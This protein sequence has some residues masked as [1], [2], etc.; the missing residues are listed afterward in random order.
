MTLSFFEIKLFASAMIIFL[1][2]LSIYRLKMIPFDLKKTALDQ[3]R[4]WSATFLVFLIICLLLPEQWPAYAVYPVSLACAYI[5]AGFAILHA[6]KQETFWQKRRN[7]VIGVASL[8]V[9][10]LV[11]PQL[12]TIPV[13]FPVLF[14]MVT[15]HVCHTYSNVFFVESM[16][17]IDA[18]RKKILEVNAQRSSDHVL[19]ECMEAAGE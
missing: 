12:I 18:V 8:T 7:R 10:A 6:Q 19:A 1:W 11:L 15:T 13:L 16:K 17:D 9:V 5:Y 2:H 4:I 14:S 3:N